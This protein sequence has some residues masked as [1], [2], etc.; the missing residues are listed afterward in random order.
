VPRYCA[1]QGL[2][3]QAGAREVRYRFLER[4]ARETGARRIALGHTANDQAE[5]VIMRLIRGAG[6]AGLSGIRPVRGAVIRPLI[7]ATRSEILVHLAEHGLD[8]V[9]DPSN[10][11]PVYARNRIRG[12]VIPVLERFNRAS[13]RPS[14][15]RPGC[16]SPRTKRWK[17]VLPLSCRDG[18]GDGRRRADRPDGLS[19]PACRTPEA[20]PAEVGG[21]RCRARSRPVRVQTD[22]AL[23]FIRTAASG[24]RLDLPCGLSLEREYGSFLLQPRRAVRPVSVPSTCPDDTCPPARLEVETAVTGPSAGAPGPG[25]YLWQAVFDYD[26]ITLPLHLRNRRP[27]DAFLPAGMGGLSKKLQDYFVDTKVPRMQRD[28]V[29]LLATEQD[30][31]WVVGMRTD[32]RFLPGPGTTKLLVVTVRSSD[33]RRQT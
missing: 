3:A 1:E 22:E 11:K 21:G 5:T 17:P 31:V 20:G 28:L 33:V 23:E 6:L 15:L 9:D 25:N 13:S 7:D 8:H 16:S 18:A 12:E 10:R 30:I 27:G 4:I 29:P 19:R 32:G 2:S 24:R 26:T 14:P